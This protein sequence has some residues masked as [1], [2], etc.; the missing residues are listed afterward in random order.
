MKK[1]NRGNSVVT[2]KVSGGKQ[3]KCSLL[4]GSSKGDTITRCVGM[5]AVHYASLQS[6]QLSAQ[7]SIKVIE[8]KIQLD[9]HADTCVV[10]D[11][12]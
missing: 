4:L 3:K 7:K 11:Q 9:S 5:D 2:H 10:G 1:G 8:T 12:C 6:V